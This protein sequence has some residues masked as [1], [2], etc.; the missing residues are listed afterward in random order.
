MKNIIFKIIKDKK[1]IVWG[2]VTLFLVAFITTATILATGFFYSG[3]TS[4]LGGKR[5]ITEAGENV[6][7]YIE[8][9][10][11]KEKALQ[12]GNAV[13]REICEEG[14]VLLKNDNNALPL[15]P[16]AK[17]SVFGKN[18][19]NLV[20]GG[21]GSAAPSQ[22]EPTKTIFDS[23]TLAGITFNPNLKEF[24]EDDDASGS[25]RDKTPGFDGGFTT[26]KTGET[27]ISKYTSNITNSYANYSDAALVIF[28]RVAGENWDLPRV[29]SDDSNKHYL[30]LDNNET[31]LLQHI[32]DSNAFDHVIVLINSSNMIDLAFLK[33]E[34]HPAYQSEI[35]GAIIIGSTGA[36]GILALGDILTGEVNPSGHTVDTVYTNYKDDPVWQNFGDNL[37]PGN[38][39]G[40]PH[41]DE[42]LLNGNKTGH[43]F[44]DYEEGIYLGYRYYETRGHIDGETWYDDNVVYPFG[45]G[46]SYT[47]FSHELVNG[48]ALESAPLNA[49]TE[50]AVEVN[51][52]NTG[53]K[54]GKDVVQIYASAPYA[55]GEI[56]KAYKVL[57]GFAKTQLLEPNETEKLS[58]TITPYDFASFDYNDANNND[59][60]GYELEQGTYTFF[61]GTDAH[62]DIDF[63]NKN[64]T[65]D[66][67][68]ENDPVT[69]FE[70]EPLFEEADDHLGSIMSRNDFDATFP[71]TPSEAECEVDA[72]F[73]T[74][75]SNTDSGNPNTYED[76]PT[77][78][79]PVTIELKKLIGKAYDDV[80][81]DSF[82]DQLTFSQMLKLF[83]EAC[84]A[85]VDIENV[86]VPKTISA[87]GPTGIVAFSGAPEVYGTCYYQSEVLL[88]Q[89]YNVE[90]AE[91][92]GN[93]IGNECLLG[94]KNISN[95]PYTGWY[96]PGVNLHRSPFSG[97]NTEY[98]SEDPFMS[99]KM[100]ASVIKSVQE[101]GVY[102]NVKHFAL[103]DQETHRSANGQ[104]SW[105]NEQAIRE[106]YLKPFEMAVKEGQSKGLMTSFNR[107]GTKWT[108]G[109]YN[110]VTVVLRNEW[111]FEGAVI[112][113][114]HTSSYMNNR[115]MIY[116]GGDANLT[117]NSFWVGAD[118]DEP[119]D[120]WVLRNAS[121]NLLYAIVNS[122][123]VRYNIIGYRLPVWQ[124]LLY[125]GDALVSTGLAVWGF[126]VIFKVFKKKENPVA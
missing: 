38:D 82:L 106:L 96:A 16:N 46:L 59:F 101:K 20:Y 49:N 34:D 110:L 60:E 48:A 71:V 22:N 112:C 89:T 40:V 54:A 18:S 114:Y 69:G 43:F 9:F 21:S 28:S 41:G 52:K 74:K 53:T 124:E 15:K 125:V 104:N 120:V 113:D 97:R 4:A 58:I 10:D 79:A 44:V 57:V 63:F 81:W 119:G 87:D 50:F 94:D 80:L 118:E 103:N 72:T 26:L 3:I 31:A 66:A 19:V 7:A 75:L 45:Y 102:A 33:F 8:D 1:V 67:R 32:C 115:Q 70:V 100:A 126:F 56:E 90:L 29:A 117:F 121:H 111:G 107:I 55:N 2:A 13:A 99:G 11:T 76:F 27:E 88:A 108:G 73:M 91:K 51:V 6:G 123:A 23:L 35:D 83:N 65:A 5:A 17:V 30:E 47:T 95:L 105:C 64:L 12:N 24:Y 14:M 78:G 98:Y 84:Y 85:T 61:V 25:P 93:A 39:S 68:F 77:T 92:Q 37:R 42:Y 109:D 86:G 62:N 122:N 116:A 36:Q